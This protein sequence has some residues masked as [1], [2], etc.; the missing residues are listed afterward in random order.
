[1]VLH[2]A[3]VSLC[4][5]APSVVGTGV[6]AVAVCRCVV[7]QG[8]VGHGYWLRWG[9]AHRGV[10]GVGCDLAAGVVAKVLWWW[11]QAAQ[12]WAVRLCEMRWQLAQAVE[13]EGG[14]ATGC[15]VLCFCCA[16]GTVFA[17]QP[18]VPWKRLVQ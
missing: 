4:G 9:A 6:A 17:L 12:V 11:W 14:G 15:L 18:E 8:S 3:F 16:R 7:L 13:A 5:W 2:C 10:T 1:M